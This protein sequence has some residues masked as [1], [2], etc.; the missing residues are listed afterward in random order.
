M[1]KKIVIFGL[2]IILVGLLISYSVQSPPEQHEIEEKPSKFIL[3]KEEMHNIVKIRKK[4]SVSKFQFSKL[5]D[6]SIAE[7]EHY[8]YENGFGVCYEEKSRSFDLVIAKFSTIH[9]A[10]SIFNLITKNLP[11]KLREPII[12]NV[13]RESKVF[14]TKENIYKAMFRESNLLVLIHGE[15]LPNEIDMYSGLI[16]DKI[17]KSLKKF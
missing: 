16:E 8:K 5:I 15:I 7:V 17:H 11:Y 1:A 13:G 10:D 14:I 3:E 12:S 6:E 9:S 4:Y 2:A